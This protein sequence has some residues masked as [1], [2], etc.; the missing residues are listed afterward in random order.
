VTKGELL[1][2]YTAIE[3]LF[4]VAL[5]IVGIIL[6][7]MRLPLSN[8]FCLQLNVYFVLQNQFYLWIFWSWI[9]I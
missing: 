7:A 4:I 1:E 5:F 8:E 6:P 2:P 9:Y 3:I